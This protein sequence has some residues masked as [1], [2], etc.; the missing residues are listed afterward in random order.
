MQREMQ[1]EVSQRDL[2]L[3]LRANAAMKKKVD[4]VSKDDLPDVFEEPFRAARLQF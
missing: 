1:V 4:L 2:E 3:F